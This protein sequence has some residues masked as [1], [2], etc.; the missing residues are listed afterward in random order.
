VPDRCSRLPAVL[1]GNT[2]NV[3]QERNSDRRTHSDSAGRSELDV[4]SRVRTRGFSLGCSKRTAAARSGGRD[5]P[6]AGRECQLVLWRLSF[7][8]LWL[9]RSRCSVRRIWYVRTTLVHGRT[10]ACCRVHLHSYF[11]T[12]C[13]PRLPD[14]AKATESHPLAGRAQAQERETNEFHS[15]HGL[16]ARRGSLKQRPQFNPETGFGSCRLVCRLSLVSRQHFP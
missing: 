7:L 2:G 15:P 4:H 3:G 8:R 1:R 10:V 12:S 13:W 16:A 14:P 5:T 9:E 11:S 6:L